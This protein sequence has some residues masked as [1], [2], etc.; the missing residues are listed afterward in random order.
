MYNQKSPRG[1]FKECSKRLIKLV[2]EIDENIKDT[3][4]N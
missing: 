1:V 4:L 2:Y 3:F